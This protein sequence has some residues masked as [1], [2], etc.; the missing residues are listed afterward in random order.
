MCSSSASSDVFI[1]NF[2]TNNSRRVAQLI[3]SGCHFVQDNVVIRVM[4]VYRL[5]QPAQDD[6]VTTTP[7]NKADVLPLDGSGAYIVEA[8]VRTTDDSGSELR[9][10]V[11]RELTA[12]SKGLEGAIDFHAPDRLALDTRVRAS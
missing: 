2:C 8:S 11:K 3:V 5:K 9:E 7:P 4:R 6:P 12:F 1:V 10:K